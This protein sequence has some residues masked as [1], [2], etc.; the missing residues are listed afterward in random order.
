M[1][2]TVI[3][4]YIIYSNFKIVLT[5]TKTKKKKQ[6]VMEKMEAKMKLLKAENKKTISLKLL[7]YKQWK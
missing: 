7:L 5:L 1:E 4:I 3:K 6:K 2:K